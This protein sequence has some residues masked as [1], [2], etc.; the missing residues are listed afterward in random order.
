[1][2]GDGHSIVGLPVTGLRGKK[3][4]N[5][6]YKVSYVPGYE[7]ASYILIGIVTAAKIFQ[8]WP[9]F[10]LQVSLQICPLNMT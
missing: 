2:S 9:E 7:T 4:K 10:I 3:M 5:L 1:M 8:A 6:G